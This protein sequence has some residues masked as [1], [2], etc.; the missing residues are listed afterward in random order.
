MLGREC[1][2]EPAVRDLHGWQALPVL[3]VKGNTIV[4]IDVA[5]EKGRHLGREAEGFVQRR[6]C[7][8]EFEERRKEGE[9]RARSGKVAAA[10]LVLGVLQDRRH[11]P[12]VPYRDELPVVP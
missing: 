3:G 10:G 1:V 5:V 6:P 11:L 7:E 4:R 12:V 8:A 9:V 2:T